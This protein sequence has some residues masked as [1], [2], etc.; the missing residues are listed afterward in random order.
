MVFASMFYQDALRNWEDLGRQQG[1][2]AAANM[3]YHYSLGLFAQLMAG[4]TLQDVQALT[5]ICAHVR[6]FPK[7]EAGWVA[8]CMAFSKAIELGLHRAFKSN[9][10]SAKHKNI[11]ELE[12]RKRTFWCV[13]TL[14]VTISG[15]LGRPMPIREEDYDVGI[16]LAVDDSLLSETGMDTSNGNCGFLIGIEAFK[17]IPIFMDM[18]R[19]LYA[20]KRSAKDYTQF[21][22]SAEKRIKTWQ[23]GWPTKIHSDSQLNLM[24]TEYLH[25]FLHEFR[26]VL[27]HPS[28]SLTKSIQFNDN[29]LRTCMSICRDMLKQVKELQQMKSLD[30]TWQSCAVYIL[31]IQ[32]ALYGHGQLKNELTTE[33]LQSLKSDMEQW[34][35]IMGDIGGLLGKPSRPHCTHRFTEYSSRPRNQPEIY[36]CF[37]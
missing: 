29:N 4:H 5:L 11:L 17:L 3:H 36:W 31:A 19:T 18:Y 15:K 32:T 6:T 10:A 8:I 26:L 1:L 14:H 22:I 28:L 23:E 37:T 9:T 7:P 16:P 2:H 25:L 35:S 12:M 34:L 21:V 33:K 30:T 24:F 27:H 20:A 13:L